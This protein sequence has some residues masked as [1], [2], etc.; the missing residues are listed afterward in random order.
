MIQPG[1]ASDV[2]LGRSKPYETDSPGIWR[3]SQAKRLS[4]ELEDADDSFRSTASLDEI[5]R[6]AGGWFVALS[7]AEKA[8][9]LSVMREL[10]PVIKSASPAEDCEFKGA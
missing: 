7:E 4:I 10:N 5:S 3:E 6:L 2:D 9:I 1:G 8:T